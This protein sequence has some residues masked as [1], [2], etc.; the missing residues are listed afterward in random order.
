MGVADLGF[1]SKENARD[2]NFSSDYRKT[3]YSLEVPVRDSRHFAPIAAPY[4][5]RESPQS[6]SL[7]SLGFVH[8]ICRTEA[9]LNIQHLSIGALVTASHTLPTGEYVWK[10][11]WTETPVGASG[12]PGL[13]RPGNERPKQARVAKPSLTRDGNA[14]NRQR[15][16]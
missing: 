1:P 3:R 8:S 16:M 13:M 11:R 9:T 7:R 15:V 14:L 5:G 6:S 4:A 2:L 10:S 12:L